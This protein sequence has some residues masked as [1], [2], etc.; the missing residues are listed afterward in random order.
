MIN[1]NSFLTADDIPFDNIC[2][3]SASRCAFQSQAFFNTPLTSPPSNCYLGG[4]AS[5]LRIHGI[6]TTIITL[7][8]HKSQLLNL[9]IPNS[10]YVPD[11]PCN[12]LSP[13]WLVQTLHNQNK[14]SSFHVFPNRCIFYLDGHII[15]LPYHPSSN[16]PV[17][18]LVFPLEAQQPLASHANIAITSP[19]PTLFHGFE[20]TLQSSTLILPFRTLPQEYANMTQHDPTSTGSL[21][22]AR[23]PR[24]HELCIHTKHG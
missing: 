7:C 15:P 5:G 13:Q 4:I 8:T 6:G 21:W 22:L 2:N 20:A 16:L 19:T 9:Y 3:S 12:L 17:Y 18:Q 11:L 10:L 23:T 14:N 24:P 1:S